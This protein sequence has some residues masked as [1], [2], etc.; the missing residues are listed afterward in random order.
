VWGELSATSGKTLQH[1]QNR[2]ARIVLRRDSSKD[3]FNVLGWI[4]LETKWKRQKCVL[5]YKCL[6]NLLPQYLGDY[7]TRNYNVHSYN[8]R[9]RSDLHLPKV[10]LSPAKK[11][12]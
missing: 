5:V 10:K 7:F 2:A 8:T 3:T 9:R 1:L 11:H 6:N 12:F 4:K